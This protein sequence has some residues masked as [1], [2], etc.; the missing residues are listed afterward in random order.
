MA[1]PDLLSQKILSLLQKK[2]LLSAQDIL[3]VLE[4]KGTP[5]NKTSVYRSLDKLLTA[6]LI[7]RHEFTEGQAQYELHN[8]HHDH[9]ICTS[10]GVV[11]TTE[12]KLIDKVQIKDFTVHHHHLTFF[13]VC[14]SCK[15]IS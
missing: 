10:C 11:Q 4:E 6:D 13:G 3:L 15:N 1:K 12:C 9:V 8:S 7:C 5:Y 2:H 14:K